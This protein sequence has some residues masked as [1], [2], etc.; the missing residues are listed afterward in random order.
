ML[1]NERVKIK[2]MGIITR[3]WVKIFEPNVGDRLEEILKDAREASKTGNLDYVEARLSVA[4]DNAQLY[5]L[6]FSAG[7]AN[8]IKE[9]AYMH[10]LED[11]RR[12]AKR[13]ADNGYVPGAISAIARVKTLRSKRGEETN[14]L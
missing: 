2:G 3:W 5:E 4:K 9:I 13:N 11:V 10:E 8:Y 7:E 12:L 6:P 14:D 1:L